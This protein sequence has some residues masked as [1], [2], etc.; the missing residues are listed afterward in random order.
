MSPDRSVPS[1]AEVGS[2]G[3]EGWPARVVVATRTYDRTI[4]DVWDALTNP[5]RIPRWSLPII[6]D[7][8]LGGRYQSPRLLGVTWEMG[9]SDSWLTISLVED[10]LGGT[11]VWNSSM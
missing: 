5:E 9:G 7:L 1:F 4:E 8:R 10:P 6:G 2:R 3:H 11:R